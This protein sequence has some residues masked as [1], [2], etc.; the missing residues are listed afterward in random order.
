MAR[1][2]TFG[3]DE[4][5]H[6][7]NRGTDKRKIFATKSDYDRFLALL[8]LCNGSIPVDTFFQGR[9]FS[10]VHM[11][12][13]GQPLVNIGA[14]CLMPNHFHILVREITDNGISRFM[15]KL[16]TGY[17]MYFNER[18]KRSGALFQ[19]RFKAEHVDS[20]RYLAYLFSY[21]HL[22]PIK[23]VDSRWKEKGIANMKGA[24]AHLKDYPYS[25]Y[26]DYLGKD[27]PEKTIVT[28]ESLPLY[29]E[30]P[31]VFRESVTEWLSFKDE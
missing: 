11:V 8:Y 2:I 27:R 14:Y 30:S 15:Q 6:I 18:A 21:I 1:R 20:D 3:V 13:R 29:F 25:S 24:K 7:Y 31:S 4:F 19:G 17:T 5:Y 22:N 23:L 16:S 10:G 28:P 9:R 12:D 26:L